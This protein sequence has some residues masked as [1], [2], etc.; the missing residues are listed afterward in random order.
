MPSIVE[1]S[2]SQHV[3]YVDYMA[4]PSFK[5]TKHNPIMPALVSPQIQT[6]NNNGRQ[7]YAMTAPNHIL[8][9]RENRPE[10]EYNKSAPNMT[11][12]GNEKMGVSGQGE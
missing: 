1:D 3:E 7:V 10:M 2:S 8:D 6:A 4:P 11:S 5:M 9:G 12:I